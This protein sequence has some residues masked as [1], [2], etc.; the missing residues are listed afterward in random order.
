MASLMAVATVP[1]LTA[2]QAAAVA[3]TEEPEALV[4]QVVTRCLT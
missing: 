3:A 2:T 1:P 4:V